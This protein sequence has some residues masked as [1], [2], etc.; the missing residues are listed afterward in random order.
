MDIST[1]FR[2]LCKTVVTDL[3]LGPLEAISE[4]K[5]LAGGVSSDI[6]MLTIGEQR[7]CIKCALAQLKVQAVWKAPVRRNLAEYRWLSFVGSLFPD[8]VP[9]LLGRSEAASGFAM[10][11][12]DP[13]SAANY[14]DSLLAREPDAGR[15]GQVGRLLAAIHA[16]STQADFDRSRFDNADDFHALRVEPYLLHTASAHP[17]VADQLQALSAAL[18]AARIA[19][20][21]GDVSPKNILYASTGPI[22]LDAE[23]ASFGDPAF[24]L[25]FFLNH[26]VLKAVHMPDQA[27]T[28]RAAAADCWQHYQSGITWE[29]PAALE[30][31]VS[32]L[33]PALALARVDGKSPA[34]YLSPAAGEQIRA[35][36]LQCIASGASS[37]L[38]TIEQLTHAEASR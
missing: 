12:I 18:D 5:A 20:I 7:V 1:D 14:K 31:R 29:S 3:Q 28:L 38:P 27:N 4:I 36:S 30:A 9:H 21:H 23:C 34:E 24:D 2:E 10:A 25:A 17:E 33:L 22:F 15:A 19:L 37:L 8:A 26:L 11:Y 16:A 6:A 13:A 35:R 32:A